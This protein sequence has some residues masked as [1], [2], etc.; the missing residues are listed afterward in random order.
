MAG[1]AGLLML[2]ACGNGDF[3]FPPKGPANSGAAPSGIPGEALAFFPRNGA[4]ALTEISGVYVGE[5]VPLELHGVGEEEIAVWFSSD[6]GKGVFLSPGELRLVGA[7]EFEIRA[8]AGNREVALRVQVDL[9]RPRPSD[10][11]I[12][13][14]PENPTP[15]PS[16]SP[17]PPPTPRPT[18]SPTSTPSPTP[19]AL[20]SPIPQPTP[21][22]WPTPLPSDPFAD[23]VVAFHPGSHAG[24]GSDRF[25]E[26]V[27]GPPK[28][29][30]LQ[31]G[32]F[33]VL[34]LGIGGDIVLKSATPFFNGPGPDLIVFENAFYAGG[35]PQAPFAEPGEVAVSQDG[36]QFFAFP[37]ASGNRDAFYP[38]C[39]GVHPVLA[40]PEL[41]AIDPTDPAAAGGDAFDLESLGLPWAR[42][43][44]IRDLGSGGGGNSAGF[45][46]DA[47]SFIHQTL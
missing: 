43:V 32:S 42:Y 13:T 15:M 33:D 45:D 2:P 24:F 23:E 40:N 27:L 31:T 7:G 8:H 12:V 28:G 38:G 21:S 10:P 3:A 44:R 25:P 41:N 30:G 47:V 6:T 5:K 1:L 35:N 16:A 34:S 17:T 18:P 46:L 19:T 9:S 22:A 4:Q 14:P 29:G 11:P 20:P 37:C 39:A 26:V 36:L